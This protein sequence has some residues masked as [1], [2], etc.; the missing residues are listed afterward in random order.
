MP[1]TVVVWAAFAAD[2][3]VRLALTEQR[4]RFLRSNWLDPR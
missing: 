4:W 2:F 3:L 1:A